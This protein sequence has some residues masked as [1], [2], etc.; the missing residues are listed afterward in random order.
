MIAADMVNRMNDKYFGQWLALNVPFRRLADLED[1]A[2]REKV[3]RRYYNLACAVRLRP[4]FWRDPEEIRKDMMLQ[5]CGDEYIDNVIRMVGANTRLVEQYLSGRI[6]KNDEAPDEGSEYDGPSTQGKRRASVLSGVQK[7]SSIKTEFDW[8]VKQRQLKDNIDSRVDQALRARNHEDPDE[9]EK[10]RDHAQEYGQAIVGLGGPGTGKTTVA[11]ASIGRAK[12]QGARIVIAVP[13]AQ[14]SSR[15]RQRFPNVEVDTCHGVFLLH[16]PEM[17]A[18]PILSQY[19]LVVV[20]EVSQLSQE[21]FER[22]MRMWSMADRVPALVFLGDFYQLPGVDPTRAT[23]SAAWKKDVRKIT[24]V[25]PWRCKCEKLMAK[26]QGTRTSRP[27]RKMLRSIVSGHRAWN[28]KT[29]P[30][31]AD[32][33]NVLSQ[34][35]KLQ[36]DTTFVTCTR[37]GA[38][39]INELVVQEL[40]HRCQDKLLGVIPGHYD[41]NPENYNKEGKLHEGRRPVPKSVKL[42]KGMRLFLTFNEDKK[43][44]FVN[45]MEVAVE[46]YMDETRSGRK[47]EC[48]VVRTKT[49]KRLSVHPITEDPLETGKD[50]RVTYFPVR[51]GYA[52]TLHKVQGATLDH[53]TIWLD[54]PGM[55]AAG[56]VALSRVQ[57]DTDYLSQSQIC[58]NMFRAVK[59]V[60]LHGM[61]HRTL[62]SIMCWAPEHV[63][64][65]FVCKSICACTSASA[66]IDIVQ[67]IPA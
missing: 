33:R 54:V 38:N 64:L 32:I 43:E 15:M 17:E 18:L 51:Y 21:H 66:R 10:A 56:H 55:K 46:G 8:H 14:M 28:G 6:D 25:Q 58:N 39:Q 61:L 57:Y 7:E 45:G 48:L 37:R 9:A 29:G 23:D 3:P 47:N 62:V 67:I 50:T 60:S 34:T 53:V 13:T 31:S 63:S 27:S 22:I 36:K 40:F 30:T 44:D 5:A 52:S 16:R 41:A 35:K 24:L 65:S 1:A 49:G 20:D 59:H 11:E 2:A 19:D 12:Q 4:E 42:Y 26:I